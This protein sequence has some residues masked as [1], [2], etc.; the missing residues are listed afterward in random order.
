MFTQKE[1]DLPYRRWIEILK[2]NDI[3]VVYH[4]GKFDVVVDALSRLSM[5][6]V[7]HAEGEK[8]S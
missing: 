2:D 4:L 6:S 8:K 3:N 7:A 1:L 5:G